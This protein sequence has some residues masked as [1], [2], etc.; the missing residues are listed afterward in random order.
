[1]SAVSSKWGRRG[2]RYRR[3]RPLPGLVL[4][5]VLVVLA[6]LMWTRVF[7]S[8]EDIEAATHCNP[9]SPPSASQNQP[10]GAAQRGSPSAEAQQPNSD[11]PHSELGTMLPRDALDQTAPTPPGDAH[12]RVLNANGE[13]QQASLAT[14]EL[15][16][17]GFG[18]GGEPDNDPVY[19]NYDLNCHGQIRFGADGAAAA[20]TLSLVVPCGQ[21]VRDERQDASV[22][23]A[24]GAD[25]DEIQTTQE[26]KQIL[27]E[28]QGQ[29]PQQAADGGPN[30]PPIDPQL[31]QDA[32]D[33]HC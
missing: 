24:L 32:R 23:L 9:P 1:M 21:L 30:S 10:G 26:A 7:E 6:G 3:R 25:F 4:L 19:P 17:L 11:Q 28:L 16:T 27:Q 33:V 2:P 8:V 31:L 12:V 22:D 5:A 15:T 14:D 18:A 29:A 20:R 13:S